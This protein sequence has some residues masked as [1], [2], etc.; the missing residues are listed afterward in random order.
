[1]RALDDVPADGS[2]RKL[3]DLEDRARAARRRVEAGRTSRESLREAIAF[4]EAALNRVKD[5]AAAARARMQAH[6]ALAANG[7][8]GPWQRDGEIER[9]RRGA[10]DAEA[11]AAWSLIVATRAICEV[12]LA[13]LKATAARLAHLEKGSTG[14][15]RGQEPGRLDPAI[16][17]GRPPGEGVQL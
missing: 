17:R 7:G 13:S 6:E 3:E 4:A 14:V 12:E 2:R 11:Y 8:V 10:E 5:D 9:I 1:M 16:V 15:G